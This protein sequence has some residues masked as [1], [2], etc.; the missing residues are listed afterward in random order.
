MLREERVSLSSFRTGPQLSDEQGKG[1]TSGVAILRFLRRNHQ[2]GRV[3]EVA[4]VRVH[5]GLRPEGDRDSKPHAKQR[6]RVDERHVCLIGDRRAHEVVVHLI[7]AIVHHSVEDNRGHALH[8]RRGERVLDGLDHVLGGGAIAFGILDELR[9]DFQALRRL[10][11]PRR[12]Q[13]VA[14]PLQSSLG[15]AVA[16]VRKARKWL[17]DRGTVCFAA[18]IAVH[19]TVW[20]GIFPATDRACVQPRTHAADARRVAVDH[21]VHAVDLVPL[22]HDDASPGL[23]RRGQSLVRALIALVHGLPAV[24]AGGPQVG[25]TVAGATARA[26]RLQA[27]HIIPP[28]I[29]DLPRAGMKAETCH[30]AAVRGVKAKVATHAIAHRGPVPRVDLHAPIR[31]LLAHAVLVRV[32]SLGSSLGSRAL[33]RHTISPGRRYVPV[34]R[35]EARL[36]RGVMAIVPRY[37]AVTSGVALRGRVLGAAVHA[38]IRGLEADPILILAGS[39]GSRRSRLGGRCRLLLLRARHLILRDSVD[40]RRAGHAVGRQARQVVTSSLGELSAQ[41]VRGIVEDEV[42]APTCASLRTPVDPARLASVDVVH[43][44][45]VDARSVPEIHRPCEGRCRLLLLRARHLI[46]RDSVDVRRAGYAVG[47]AQL[48][49]QNVRGIVEDEVDAPALANLCTPVDPA[50]CHRYPH[51]RVHIHRAPPVLAHFARLTVD[52]ARLTR[53]A[54]CHG[55]PEHRC[56]RGRPSTLWEAAHRRIRGSP[57]AARRAAQVARPEATLARELKHLSLDRLAF[58]RLDSVHITRW[59]LA[60][61]SFRAVRPQRGD[62][63]GPI[64][65]VHL[66]AA[67]H[68]QHVPIAQVGDNLLD[69]RIRK[70]EERFVLCGDA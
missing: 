25:V 46:L 16:C 64:S 54:G 48:S 43:P 37:A 50:R 41:N 42:D 68:A 32:G 65:V 23:R 33:A 66:R 45:L 10:R 3:H 9:Q 2:T 57:A 27:L 47:L 67:A 17:L 12:R 21:V 59:V 58:D 60:L 8:R 39:L 62:Q 14:H 34:A 52:L 5:G 38:P 22:E 30:P 53:E 24:P 63:L 6:Q 7:G 4:Q 70:S 13:E 51:H 61:R 40:V 44:H 15:V 56:S 69:L 26:G 19:A 20:F 49:A 28:G 1:P 35:L 55:P 18:H 36:A 11:R 31:W 29:R